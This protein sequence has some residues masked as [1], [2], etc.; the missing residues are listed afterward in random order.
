MAIQVSGTEVISNSRALNNIASVDAATVTA[1]GNAGVG[2]TPTALG[3]VGTYT[4]AK[5]SGMTNGS[6][7]NYFYKAGRTA[8]GSAL[9]TRAI[10]S[11]N[12][13]AG[14]GTGE[15]FIATSTSGTTG[16][17]LGANNQYAPGGYITDDNTQA[18]T[19]RMMSP[20]A[21]FM[22]NNNSSTWGN[23]MSALWVRYV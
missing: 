19:W 6:S 23:F 10:V 22:T 14:A 1:F 15:R 9:E 3:A 16:S 17:T 13:R 7:S 11:G 2:G 5:D 8:A 18:G 21:M 4:I 12:T 20:G